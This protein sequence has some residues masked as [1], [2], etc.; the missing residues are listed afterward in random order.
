[1]DSGMVRKI[2]KAKRYAQERD[3]L[4]FD[5]LKV[6]FA[7]ANNPH[8]VTFENGRWQCDCDFF[9]LHGRCSHTM[10]IEYIFEDCHLVL[11][12]EVG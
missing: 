4:R 2:E 12:E 5:A 10:A 1:M 9:R 3:R 7:G 6:T 8:V 11:A